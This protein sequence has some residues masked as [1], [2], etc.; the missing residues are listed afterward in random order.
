MRLFAVNS[1][2]FRC[3]SWDGLSKRMD[4]ILI[5]AGIAYLEKLIA[6]GRGHAEIDKIEM[7]LE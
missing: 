1:D 4:L 6:K 7:E 3:L 5:Q 2:S